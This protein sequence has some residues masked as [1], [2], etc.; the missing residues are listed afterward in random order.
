M[1]SS[2]RT[3]ITDNGVFAVSFYRIP[4]QV[5]VL[6]KEKTGE[7]LSKALSII[8]CTDPLSG[9]QQF[10]DESHAAKKPFLSSNILREISGG[11]WSNSQLLLS[12]SA[13]LLIFLL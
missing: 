6:L 12:P 2:V 9:F 3:R 1:F 5:L 11:N 4:R 10:I 7:G 13:G 8:R